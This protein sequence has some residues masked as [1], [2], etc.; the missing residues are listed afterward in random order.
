M[1]RLKDWRVV[2]GRLVGADPTPVERNDGE[3]VLDT[4]V[5]EPRAAERGNDVVVRRAL[6]VRRDELRQVVVRPCPVDVHALLEPLLERAEE[7]QVQRLEQV[8]RV[9]RE[10]L[11]L[12]VVVPR[13]FFD[14]LDGVGGA[15]VHQGYQTVR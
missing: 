14:L 10:Q 11:D 7:T 5:V 1:G 13:V 3:I 6:L 12:D 2:V 15:P 8:R 4:R 9:R